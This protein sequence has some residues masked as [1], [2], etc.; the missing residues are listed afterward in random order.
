MEFTCLI[1]CLKVC[2]LV[3]FGVKIEFLWC[4]FFN[5]NVDQELCF[6]IPRELMALNSWSGPLSV[7]ISAMLRHVF[8][9]AFF[10]KDKMR[11]VKGGGKTDCGS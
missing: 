1:L 8:K 6:Q 11:I 3:I 5:C 7:F 4:I 10:N 9:V 2:I